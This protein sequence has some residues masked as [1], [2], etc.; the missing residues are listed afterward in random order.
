MRNAVKWG[1]PPV[2]LFGLIDAGGRHRGDQLARTAVVVEGVGAEEGELGDGEERG[3]VGNLKSKIENP[4][5]ENPQSEV[6][7]HQTIGICCQECGQEQGRGVVVGCDDFVGEG[8]VEG[9]A[10]GEDLFGFGGGV[11]PG[12]AG[13]VVGG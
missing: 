8:E 10:L 7:R 9:V 11:G 5:S 13:A 12:E 4:K 6:A 2:A 1:L 3:V